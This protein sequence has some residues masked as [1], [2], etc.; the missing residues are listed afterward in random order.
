MGWPYKPSSSS[1]RYNQFPPPPKKLNS[2]ENN[3][4]LHAFQGEATFQFILFTFPSSGV[5]QTPPKALLEYHVRFLSNVC[6]FNHLTTMQVKTLYEEK[7]V[8]VLV[9]KD[10]KGCYSGE[11]LEKTVELAL[12]CTQSHPNL[13]PKMSEVLK[14]LEGITGQPAHT[15]ESQAGNNCE[16]R[17]HS[18]SRN[19]SDDAH[20][21]S[22]F[23]IEAMELSGPR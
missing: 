18:F 15:E 7:K 14:V 9:D 20:G 13:R 4:Q 3:R 19:Y 10:L 17:N 5:N 12:L 22:S 21:D 8:E 6:K 23:I 1:K 11:E 16:E 2:M